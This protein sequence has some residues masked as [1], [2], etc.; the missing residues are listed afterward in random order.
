MYYV[1]H[2]RVHIELDDELVAKVDELVG[3]RGR[4]GFLRAAIERAVRL[5]LRWADIEAAAGTIAAQGHDWDSDPAQWVRAQ[6]RAD[7]RRAG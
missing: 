6:R 7:S 2:M 1:Q 3:P 5:D 4:N